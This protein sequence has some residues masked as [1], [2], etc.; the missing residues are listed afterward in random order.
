MLYQ[1]SKKIDL[2]DTCSDLLDSDINR[3]NFSHQNLEETRSLKQI[4]EHVAFVTTRC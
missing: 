4:T 2:L 3:H 1:K